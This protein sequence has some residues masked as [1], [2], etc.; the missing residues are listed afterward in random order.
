MFHRFLKA[1]YIYYQLYS[2]YE[3]HPNNT[4]LVPLGFLNPHTGWLPDLR[5][6]K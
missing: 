5:K 6:G 4:F 1:I 3:A 2:I